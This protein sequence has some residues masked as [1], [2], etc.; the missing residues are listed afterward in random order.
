VSVWEWVEVQEV[1]FGAHVSQ[2]SNPGYCMVL[3]ASMLYNHDMSPPLSTLSNPGGLIMRI[4]IALLAVSLL[5]GA[6]LAQGPFSYVDFQLP[7][8]EIMILIHPTLDAQLFSA[9]SSTYDDPI[10]VRVGYSDLDPWGMCYFIEAMP[11]AEEVMVVPMEDVPDLN[12]LDTPLILD[13]P[14]SGDDGYT[15]VSLAGLRGGGYTSGDGADFQGTVT[16]YDGCPFETMFNV[17]IRST[18]INGDL[19]VNL[20]DIVRFTEALNSD[21]FF[22]W[23]DFTPDGVINLSDIVRMSHGLFDQ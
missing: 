21:Q 10:D 2:D 19:V 23:A 11:E 13:S 6:A 16:G 5:S 14:P 17:T 15:T 20:S 4:T 8:D 18:D 22:D 3:R 12:L 9:S 7:S 1:L